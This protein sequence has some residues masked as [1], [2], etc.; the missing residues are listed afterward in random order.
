M[1]YR[2]SVLG[3]IVGVLVGLTGMGGG[4]LMTPALILFHLARPTLAVGTDLVWNAL[5]KAVGSAVHLRQSTVDKVIVKRLALGSLPGAVIGIALLAHLR[6]LGIA[7]QD[8]LVVDI[9]G[10]ALMAAALG[11]FVRSVFGAKLPIPGE[12]CLSLGPPWLTTVLG[13]IVGFLVSMTSVGSGSLIVACLVFIYPTTP[14]RRI[15]GSDIVNALLLVGVAALGHLELGSINVHLL[16]GLL[17]GSIP[18][19]WIG[20]RMATLFPEKLLRPVLGTTLLYLG[21]RLL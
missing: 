17:I 19:V 5:T 20:S 3:F 9:L 11:L 15:V 16:V 13:L 12:Q 14:L 6:R 4:A 2:I 7:T 1:D 10:V 18:G 8:K 21:L